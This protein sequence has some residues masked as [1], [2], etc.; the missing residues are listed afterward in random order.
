MAENCPRSV[1]CCGSAVNN[2]FDL[3]WF[4]WW[5]II[6]QYADKITHGRP[7]HI[8]IDQGQY[9]VILYRHYKKL[10]NGDYVLFSY[11][12]VEESLIQEILDKWVKLLEEGFK[13]YKR[14]ITRDKLNDRATF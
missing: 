1:E 9:D 11:G 4:D 3:I 13:W 8:S 6:G 14:K 10:Y 7:V 2:K 5:P 12:I